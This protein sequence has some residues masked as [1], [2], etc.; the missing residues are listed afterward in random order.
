MEWAK[1]HAKVRFTEVE[2]SHRLYGKQLLQL[3]RLLQ[4]PYYLGDKYLHLTNS[5]DAVML[6]LH[7]G[8]LGQYLDNLQNQ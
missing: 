7:A 2:M 1:S 5:Q 6:Q 4:E 3:E 8:N